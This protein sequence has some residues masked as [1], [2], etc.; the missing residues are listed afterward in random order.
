MYVVLE[1]NSNNSVDNNPTS[2][3]YRERPFRELILRVRRFYRTYGWIYNNSTRV[4]IVAEDGSVQK[5]R[6]THFDGGQ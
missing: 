2:E 4:R 1:M 6:G 5:N 3:T